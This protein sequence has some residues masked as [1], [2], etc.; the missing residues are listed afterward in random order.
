MGQAISPPLRLA[1]AARL[2]GVSADT[3]R[4]LA[5]AGLIGHRRSR[6]GAGLYLFE[7][8]HI[9]AYLDSTRVGVGE[10]REQTRKLRW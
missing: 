6:P 9:D 2:L 10:G 4:D 8:E 1:A 3:L 7:R 5:R